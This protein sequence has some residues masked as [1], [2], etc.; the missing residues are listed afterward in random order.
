MPS[1][2]TKIEEVPSELDSLNDSQVDRDFKKLIEVKQS[3]EKLAILMEKHRKTTQNLAT[4]NS[5]FGPT[6][7]NIFPQ[8]HFYHQEAN[9]IKNVHARVDT[10]Y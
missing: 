10:F 7:L 2:N 6:S 9:R 4:F 3:V 8:Q 5:K 1:S